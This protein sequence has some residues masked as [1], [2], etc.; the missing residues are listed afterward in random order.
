[1]SKLKASVLII[2]IILVLGYVFRSFIGFND[3]SIS[4]NT[5]YSIKRTE[6]KIYKG[7]YSHSSKLF[8]KNKGKLIFD[9]IKFLPFDTDYG[10]NDFLVVYS[11]SF[12]TKFRHFKTTNRMYDIYTFNLSK[13]NNKL[14]LDV[15]IQGTDPKVFSSILKK[16]E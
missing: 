14:I 6:I 7:W 8:P 3:V 2:S 15:K 13:S 9:G 11:D 5:S 12:Y 1:M 16:V 4:L 10:E